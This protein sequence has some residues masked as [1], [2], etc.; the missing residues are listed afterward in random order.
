MDL[1]SITHWE[2]YSRA[3]DTMTVHTSIPEAPWY[4]V[5][6]DDKRASRLN[7]IN[8]LLTSIDYVEVGRPDAEDAQAPQ[9]GRLRA[10][11]ARPRA[12]RA[13]PRRD[14]HDVGTPSCPSRPARSGR[15]GR[16]E[17]VRS[18]S[19]HA[20]E[21]LR[22][23]V[24]RARRD[25]RAE[26]RQ[27]LGLVVVVGRDAVV[28]QRQQDEHAARRRGPSRRPASAAPSGRRPRTGR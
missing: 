17:R 18:A 12:L 10:P 26:G 28:G 15:S 21:D 14:A 23:L 20:G 19:Q 16:T 22:E 1:K 9:A 13:R 6:S 11:A 7:M 2:D 5:E 25:R 4:I 24:G 27:R 8:H 3:K